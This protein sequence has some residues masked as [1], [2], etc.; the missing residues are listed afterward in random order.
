MLKHSSAI[1]SNYETT[2]TTTLPFKQRKTNISTEWW[3]C[4]MKYSC[5]RA[6]ILLLQQGRRDRNQKYV[7]QKLPV[8]DEL[9]N[10]LAVNGIVRCP[11]TLSGTGGNHQT[12]PAIP[13]TIAT[14]LCRNKKDKTLGHRNYTPTCCCIIII[15]II[16]TMIIV[17][18][19]KERERESGNEGLGQ[20]HES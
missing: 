10:L 7:T 2:F 1:V 11:S 3:N 9:F 15:I 5:T 14:P 20:L 19:V 17:I 8:R 4:L 12:E 6:I 16:P 13:A 18:L